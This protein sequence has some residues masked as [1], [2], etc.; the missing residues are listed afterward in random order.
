[1]EKNR[2]LTQVIATPGDR[3]RGYLGGSLRARLLSLL[4]EAAHEKHHV[5]AVL[6]E[7]DDPELMPALAKLGKRAHVVLGNGSVKKK[8]LDQNR[9]A[10]MALRKKIQLLP[11]MLSPR[12]LAHNKFLVICDRKQKPLRVWTGS[13]NWTKSG[14]C[15]QANNSVLIADAA[16]AGEYRKQWDLLRR[17]RNDTPDALIT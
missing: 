3:V 10:R 4:D 7:L 11:R 16:I 15:T 5:Y 9:K 17:A 12:A 8:G 2:K 14:L 13:T 1:K 6:Y